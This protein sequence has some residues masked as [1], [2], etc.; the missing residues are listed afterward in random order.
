MKALRRRICD[1]RFLALLHRFIKAGH[2]DRHLFRATH[3][4]VPQGGVISPLLS[5][6]MLHEFDV[7]MESQFLS[8]KVRKDRWAWNDTIRR[9]RPIA[10]REKRQWRPA[11]S[12]TRYADDFVVVVKGSKQDAEA[13][14]EACRGYL[15]G[16][17]HLTLNMDKTH[18]THVNDGFVFLGH[19]IIRKRGATGRLRP[20]TTIPW[21][22]YR[23]FVAK[24]VRE[25]STDYSANPLDL[26]EHLNQQIQG[27]ANFYRYT[28]Y[29]ATLFS[30]ID[31]VIFWKMGYWLA[32]KYHKGF[33]SLMARYVRAPQPGTAKTWALHGRTGEGRYVTMALARLVTS[34]KGRFLWRTPEQNPY[35]LLPADR[36]VRYLESRYADV[37]IAL[38]DT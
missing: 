14:R 17:L 19:R 26:I 11:V 27:W 20:V 15:E 2:I 24:I 4:G 29:T 13:V 1:D 10:I 18:I 31:R 36:P 6:I 34:P 12:Y 8:P 25:L 37:A 33:R 28:D 32:R 21:E 35:I 5:N 9:Q 16:T 23:G 7:W 3:Q 38:S 22:K 30:R